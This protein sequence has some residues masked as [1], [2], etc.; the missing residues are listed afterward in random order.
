MFKTHFKNTLDPP[1]FTKGEAKAGPLGF[2]PS[3]S[4]L[5]HSLESRGR[6]LLRRKKSNIRFFDVKK[7]SF[8]PAKEIEGLRGLTY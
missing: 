1:C 2:A 5:R 8:F 6:V 7:G 3:I 4:E